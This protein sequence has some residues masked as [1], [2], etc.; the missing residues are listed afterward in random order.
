M[1]TGSPHYVLFVNDLENYNVFE[2][3][4]KLRY[5]TSISEQGT[6]VDFVEI[7]NENEIAVRTYE[8]GVENE[9]LACGTGAIAS[10]ISAHLKNKSDNFSFTIRA[11]GGTLKVDFKRDTETRFTDI[12]LTGPAKYV[13]KGTVEIE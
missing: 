3:G 9:T 1:N 5:D 8:R 10:A 2:K 11:R 6:N 4:R 7:I 13:F 12:W